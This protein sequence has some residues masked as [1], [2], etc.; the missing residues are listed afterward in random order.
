MR[1]QAKTLGP[2]S[3]P[4]PRHD[5]WPPPLARHR[6]PATTHHWPPP[7]L[8]QP[9]HRRH[10]HCTPPSPHRVLGDSDQIHFGCG[11]SW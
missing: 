3:S 6:L 9:P 11:I 7:L 4:L 2:L 8:L 1:D 10:L 5:C